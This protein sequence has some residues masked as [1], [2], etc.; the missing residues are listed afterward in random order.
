MPKLPTKLHPAIAYSL[1]AN[2]HTRAKILDPLATHRDPLIR[3][4]IGRHP[5]LAVKTQR[6]LSHDRSPLVHRALL[7]RSRLSADI[8]TT[9]V[10]LY[11]TRSSR[12]SAATDL[13]TKLAK[14][15]ATPRQALERLY[16]LGRR[17]PYPDLLNA[18]ACNSK[19]PSEILT[20]L[21]TDPI[22]TLR[23]ALIQNPATPGPLRLHLQ[24]T[25]TSTER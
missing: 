18:L 6:L 8:L 1:A 11:T 24:L 3:H 10:H 21:A 22:P 2:P 12:A 16:R 4:L 13:L 5:Q 15:R 17:H 23:T 14:H 9:L 20:Q 25:T 19:T 7:E